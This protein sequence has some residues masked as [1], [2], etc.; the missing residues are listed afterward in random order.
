MQNDYKRL[1]RAFD[2]SVVAI[3]SSHEV[4]TRENTRNSSAKVWHDQSQPLYR[5]LID[6]CHVQPQP[7]AQIG[8]K[9]V[10]LR[11]TRPSARE[12]RPSGPM[13]ADPVFRTELPRS[14]PKPPR[15][16]QALKE[17]FGP[18]AHNARHS[19][20]ITGWSSHAFGLSTHTAG[21]STYLTG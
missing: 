4:K 8:G 19:K 13:A 21:W 9:P 6:T 11:M 14:V 18:S 17:Q 20:Y 15:P 5:M 7:P 3:F 16:V 12:H 10:D 1:T 2:K